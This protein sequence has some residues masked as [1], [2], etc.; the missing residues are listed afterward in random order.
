MLGPIL[1][2]VSVIDLPNSV[3]SNLYMF[4]DDRKLCHSIKSKDDCDILQQDLDNITNW[5]RI[6]LTKLKSRKCKV[7]SVGTQISIVH[8]YSMTYPDGYFIS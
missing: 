8:T 2:L 3:L 5:G 1:F 6:W 7:L 4:S